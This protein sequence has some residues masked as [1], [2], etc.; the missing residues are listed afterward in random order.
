MF[1]I[2]G[3]IKLYLLIQL[4]FGSR[5][6]SYVEF[7]QYNFTFFIMPKNSYL[8]GWVG[9]NVKFV[10][11]MIQFIAV[12]VNNQYDIPTICNVTLMV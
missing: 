5:F 12:C 4:F 7:K 11:P 1:L 8:D 3:N 9:F 2:I 10:L 6:D